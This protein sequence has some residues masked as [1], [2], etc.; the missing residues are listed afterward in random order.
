[1]ASISVDALLDNGVHFG[2]R[3]SRWNPKM[4]PFI[5]GKRNT[6]HII[7]LKAT[8]R[9][10]I[11]ASNYLTRATS[12]G[13][14][15]LFVGTKRSAR[16]AV[17]AVAARTNMP[18]VTGRWLGG[19]LTNFQTIRSRLRRL[20][21]LEEEEASGIVSAMKKKAQARHRIEKKKI[22][23]NLEGIRE[24][25]ALP[26]CLVVVDPKHEQIAVAEA[27]KMRIP[28]IALL[29][30]DCDPDVVDLPIPG[31]DDA[32]RSVRLILDVLADAVV[33]GG[34]VWGVVLAE[35]EK[36]EAARRK[37]EDQRREAERQ[38]AQVTA[39]WQ[40][41]LR[42]E[43]DRRRSG[44]APAKPD[45]P[46]PAEEAAAPEQAKPAEAPKAAE[47]P[48]AEEAAA[49]EEPKA[50]EPKAEEPKA[51]AEEPKAE[52]P[53]PADEPKAEEP[54]ADE[55]PKVEEPKAEAEAGS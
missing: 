35:R 7:D 38:R 5:H 52:E 39:E 49:P 48:K 12:E 33:E 28:V 14:A 6:I 54:K 40:K 43:A 27:N 3:A 36:V 29:D 20:A 2:H 31:N 46:K 30:T 15:V 9:G 11:R 8:V 13:G 34:K 53:K 55:K 26:A 24:M 45:A 10:L 23:K 22:L 17:R 44:A 51:K 32:M 18:Y 4:K 42:D 19:T 25:A 47:K 50:E 37:E 1:L 16:E 21:E 41:R